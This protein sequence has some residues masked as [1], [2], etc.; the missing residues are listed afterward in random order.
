MST[1]RAL[2]PEENRQL[3]RG[4]LGLVCL[5]QGLGLKRWPE[6]ARGTLA[7]LDL[8]DALKRR[9]PSGRENFVFVKQGWWLGG[10]APASIPRTDPISVETVTRIKPGGFTFNYA[11]YFPGTATFAWIN[12]REFGFPLNLIDPQKVY[13]SPSPPPLEAAGQLRSFA[14]RVGRISRE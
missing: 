4:C 11:V 13:V 8:D 9:C 12:H 14:R 2:T 3:D 7:Y 6:S 5:Y 10:A 1:H